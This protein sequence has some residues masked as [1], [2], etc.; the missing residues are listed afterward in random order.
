MSDVAEDRLR[1]LAAAARALGRSLPVSRLVELA[2]ES[3]REGLGA[4]GVSLSRLEPGTLDV[5][6]LARVGDLGRG[7]SLSAPVVVD[8]R[9]WGELHATR[10]VGEAFFDDGDESYLE[11]LVAVLAGAISRALREES[12]ERLAFQDP[13][14]GLLNR[15]ALDERA[16]RT[17]DVPPGAVRTVT[18]VVVDVNGLKEVND[19]CGHVVGD[20]LLQ[21][22][23][24]SLDRNFSRFPGALVARVGGDEFAVLVPR[25]EP[26][27]VVRI[28]DETASLTWDLGPGAGVSVGAASARVTAGCG[29]TA[30][31]LLVAA[32]RAQ[33][34]AKRQRLSR[35]V[36]AEQPAPVRE[37]SPA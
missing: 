10:H 36:V 6:T 30:A 28:A 4:A 13:L 32:D 20:Q 34:A 27:L 35:A 1:H 26:T 14:T 29:T 12:L 2:A 9:L 23:A 22:V 11:A 18:A 5:R 8:G 16:P 37:V 17:F 21:S 15:R 31:D 24:R 33:Y 3:A 25:H 19:S 7:C